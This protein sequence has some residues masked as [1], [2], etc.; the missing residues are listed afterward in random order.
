MSNLPDFLLIL[1]IP[2]LAGLGCPKIVLDHMGV[3]I[4]MFVCIKSRGT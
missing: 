4:I 2:Q 1:V 3:Y